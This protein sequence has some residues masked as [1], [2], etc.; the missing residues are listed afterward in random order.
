MAVSREQALPLDVVPLI[1]EQ[2]DNL[3]T[4]SKIAEACPGFLECKLKR[5]FTK[6]VPTCLYDAWSEKT[7]SCAYTVLDI[8][9]RLPDR[10]ELT[11]L[12]ESLV[13]DIG[14]GIALLISPSCEGSWA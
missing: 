12:M 9:K 1:F 3:I 2:V 14:P 11:T 5:G 10:T 4:L 8:Q 13:E 7:L 6:L